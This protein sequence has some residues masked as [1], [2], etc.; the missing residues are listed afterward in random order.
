MGTAMKRRVTEYWLYQ[1]RYALSYSLALALIVIAMVAAAL[2]VPSG[3]RD[4]EM[5]SAVTSGQLDLHEFDPQAVVNLPY[6][7]LQLASISLF[8]VGDFSLKLP[9][10]VL[11]LL[12]VIGMFLLIKEWF[13]QNVAVITV[14]LTATMPS[15]LFVAQDATAQIFPVTVAIWLL[16]C[17]T[18]VTRRYKPHM[19]WK[20]I[21][22]ILLALNMYVPLGVY[23][24][25]AVIST[26]IFHPHIRHMLRRL[27]PNRVFVAS[28]AGVVISV[29]LLYSLAMEPSLGLQL[30]GIPD[31]RPDLLA[32]GIALAQSLVWQNGVTN[33]VYHPVFSTGILAIMIIGFVRFLQV[34]YT[35]RSYIIW[36]WSLILLPLLLINPQLAVISLPLAMLMIA[37]GMNTLIAEWYKLFPYNPYARVLGLIPLSVI[38]LGIVLSAGSRYAYN[39]HYNPEIANNF[40][41]DTRLLKQTLARADASPDDT[42]PVVVDKSQLAYYQLLARYD[43]R[44]TVSD[45]LPDASVTTF[46]LAHGIEPPASR[47][48]LLPSYITVSD[49]SRDSDRFYLY[50]APSN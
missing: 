29:P 17:G 41:T 43:K 21:F 40:S 18:Y 46:V 42:V 14:F 7:I 49:Q 32:N 20:V 47:S 16:V 8:G 44:F 34:K 10:L 50:T 45:K 37:M 13:R 3:L 12:A 26:I 9:S 36:L 2:Y 6:H 5:L 48:E 28:L 38:V 23:L 39:Y 30:A 15:F 22:G 1:H 11:G 31:S 33:G 25:L 27:D 35:A 24:N 4:A 19:L